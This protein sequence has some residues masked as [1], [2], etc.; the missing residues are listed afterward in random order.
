MLSSDGVGRVGEGDKWLM[1]EDG[2]GVDGKWRLT[3]RERDGKGK[4]GEKKW[5]KNLKDFFI[6]I[7]HA[8]FI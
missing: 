5:K 4:K 7:F 1:K 6:Y 8:Y 2:N 3:K